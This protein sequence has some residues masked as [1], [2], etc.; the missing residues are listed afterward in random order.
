MDTKI[1]P[2]KGK[3]IEKRRK[4]WIKREIDAQMH[5]TVEWRV[6]WASKTQKIRDMSKEI[7]AKKYGKIEI[8]W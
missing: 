4:W 3:K 2:K 1:P 5:F 6:K 8:E 7:H